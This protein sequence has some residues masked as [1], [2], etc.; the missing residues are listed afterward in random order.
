MFESRSFTP[1]ELRVADASKVVPFPDLLRRRR[2]TTGQGPLP[3]DAVVGDAAA[4]A[5]RA[6]GLTRFV[7]PAPA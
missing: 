3:P 1:G 2:R 7:R 6:W 5:A 4:I